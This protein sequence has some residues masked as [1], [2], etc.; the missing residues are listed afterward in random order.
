MHMCV[1]SFGFMEE[2]GWVGAFLGCLRLR[3]GKHAYYYCWAMGLRETKPIQR[4]GIE[5][6]SREGGRTYCGCLR[7][8]KGKL[9]GC[10]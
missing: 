1:H 2:G 8:R 10:G 7:L 4:L 9:L 3:G 6:G 5:G